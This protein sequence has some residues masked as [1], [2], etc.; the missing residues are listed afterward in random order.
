MAAL[1]A[2]VL[3]SAIGVAPAAASEPATTCSAGTCNVVF[4]FTGEAQEWTVPASVSSAT[5]QLEGAQGGS[6]GSVG[7]IRAPGGDGAQ[8]VGTLAVTPGSKLEVRVG[9]QGG[10]EG[11]PFGGY[12]GGAEGSFS[13]VY[14]DNGGGGGGASDVREGGSESSDRALVA[15]GGGGSGGD[16]A[17]ADSIEAGGEGGAGGAEAGGSGKDGVGTRPGTGGGGASDSGPG[18]GGSIGGFDGTGAGEG[19]LATGTPYGG[20]GGG[21]GGY[22]G[23]G[24]G[25]FAESPNSGGGGGGGGSSYAAAIAGT[26]IVPGVHEG[27][28]RVV[29]TY[30]APPAVEVNPKAIVFSGEQAQSTVSAPQPVS[31]TDTGEGPLQIAGASFAGN[32]P[33]DFLIGSSTCGGE[34]AAGA[35]CTLEVR[36]D[37]QATGE[38][39]ATL[40]I[41]SNAPGSPS[42]VALSGTGGALPQGPQGTQGSQGTKGLTGAQGPGGSQGS[43]GSTGA[44]GSQGPAGPTG[45]TGATGAQGPAGPSGKVE[46]ITCE[47]TE[48]D[49]KGGQHCTIKLGSTPIKFTS[50][51]NKLAAVLRRGATIYAKGFAV[52]T[53]GG[54]ALVVTPRR[55]LAKGDYTLT[56]KRAG[57]LT[58]YSIAIE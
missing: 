26:V 25:G 36:F 30:T 14:C 38:R 47:K 18:G 33:E 20:G 27:N 23:G 5:F 42:L 24:G 52:T 32:D 41:A 9:G 31:I 34:I 13:P 49:G 44:T 37:P 46:L 28:G 56:L 15:A 43:A 29:I 48:Q 6:A 21:G 57:K 11:S 50:G 55:K 40:E 54:R 7:C 35:S 1:L 16:G 58:R 51:G 45:D 39:T 17:G 4:A 8:L 22:Y 19:G 10:G 12:N 53:T 2:G 3:H